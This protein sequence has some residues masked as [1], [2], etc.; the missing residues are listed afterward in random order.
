MRTRRHRKVRK[1]P[2]FRSP[3]RRGNKRMQKMLV[4]ASLVASTTALAGARDVTVCL[5]WDHEVNRPTQALAQECATRIY[6]SIGIDLR[7]KRSCADDEYN[8]PGTQWAPNLAM[9]GI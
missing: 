7:W 8:A 5:P 9:I 2:L 3:G 1:A 6:R 4:L